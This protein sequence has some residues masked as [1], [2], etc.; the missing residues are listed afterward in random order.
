LIVYP[1]LAV[2]V[3]VVGGFGIYVYL[4][5][6]R[7]LHEGQARQAL[8]QAKTPVA[9]VQVA[10]DFPQTTHAVLALLQ[11]AGLSFDQKDYAG[12][13]KD[14][15]RAIDAAGTTDL[16]RDSARLGLASA[17]EAAGD[18]SDAIANYLAVARRGNASPYAPYAYHAAAHLDEQAA[19]V[20]NE[21]KILTE[22]AALGGDSP[23]VKEAQSRLRTLSL[24][25]FPS[26]GAAPTNPAPSVPATPSAGGAAAPH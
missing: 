20:G 3:L 12:A 17:Q 15:Q 14:Y 19:D 21:R 7:E 2:L 1:L 26:P 13:E 22:A 9:L 16:L 6:Q 8:L 5:N 25:N 4:Q 24:G 23:F 10:E 18:R 11:A